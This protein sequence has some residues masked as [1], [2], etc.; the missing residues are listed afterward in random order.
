MN[1]YLKLRIFDEEDKA[2][3][4]LCE[5]AE[6]LI[7]NLER[8]VNLFEDEDF[9]ALAR[10]MLQEFERGQAEKRG[11][12]TVGEIVITRTEGRL[13]SLSELS[14]ETGI[15]RTKLVRHVHKLKLNAVR[16][17]SKRLY[18]MADLAEVLC[19]LIA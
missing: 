19:K 18:N 4:A 10:Y 7:R 9:T 1:P 12:F 15:E 16:S 8:G 14:R 2:E 6:P 13:I 3:K 11:T 5:R 17:K